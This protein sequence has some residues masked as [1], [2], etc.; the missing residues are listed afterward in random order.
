M[1]GQQEATAGVVHAC[2]A[3]RETLI[4]KQ[5]KSIK[6]KERWQKEK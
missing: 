5:H 6:E 1:P 4:K 3:G 2:V